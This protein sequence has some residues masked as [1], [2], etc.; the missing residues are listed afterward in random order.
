MIVTF[1][2]MFKPA[3]DYEDAY[4]KLK[5]VQDKAHEEKSVLKISQSCFGRTKL[6]FSGYKVDY[7]LYQLRTRTQSGE[8]KDEITLGDKECAVISRLSLFPQGVHTKI[9]R[10]FGATTRHITKE[11]CLRCGHNRLHA[12]L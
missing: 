1:D 4:N 7:G 6:L 9:C 11:I 10:A 5:Q 3:H 8:T 12:G 2:N